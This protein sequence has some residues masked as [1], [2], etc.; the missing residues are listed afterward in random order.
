[1]SVSPQFFGQTVAISTLPSG[2]VAEIMS[3]KD[4]VPHNDG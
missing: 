2:S 3:A 4:C 1:M